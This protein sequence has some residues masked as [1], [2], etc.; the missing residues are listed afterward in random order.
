MS[1]RRLERVYILFQIFFTLLIWTPVFYEA[2]KL[3]GLSDAQIFSIQTIYYFV[4]A[5]AEIPTGLFADF[6]G[7]LRSMKVGATVLAVANLLPIV[8]PNHLGFLAHFLLLALAR[9]LI[10]GASSAYLYET[11]K[12][13]G[14]LTTYKGIEGRARAY[15]LVVRVVA[16]AAAGWLLARS[17]ALPYAITVATAC[18]ALAAA[19]KLPT[20]VE[21]RATRAPNA[22][23]TLKT[24][25][26]T[27]GRA[28]RTSPF[29]IL[30]MMQGVAIFVLSRIVIVNLFQ[31]ILKGKDIPL[32]S[33]GMVLGVMT[34][35]EA[36]GS[37]KPELLSRWLS[38][39]RTVFFV[40]TVMALAVALLPVLPP[41]ATILALALFSAAAGFAFP[42]QKQLMNTAIPD[43]SLR[44]TLLS[45]ESIIDRLATAGAASLLT[46]FMTMGWMNGFL[47]G[48]AA[49]LFGFSTILVAALRRALAHS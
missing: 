42:V 39:F 37:F 8:A 23:F 43:S 28:L 29:L 6:F 16:F 31:P 44:A 41:F 22:L 1:T 19:F 27:T 46:Y 18:I 36:I 15:S 10:S 3:S 47:V 9:S 2:Q 12:G 14:E 21:E 13:R 32:E 48:A 11:L 24:R 26:V 5:F 30:V 49:T 7:T 4:F 20:L 25:L 38:D 45:V 35:A 33:H 17:V 34:L 40:T